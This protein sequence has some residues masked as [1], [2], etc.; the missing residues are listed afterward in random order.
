MKYALL[1]RGV[2]VG[3]RTKL[4]MTDLRAALEA[5]GFDDVSTYLQ[6]GNAVVSVP[7]RSTTTK[8]AERVRAAFDA[9]LPW[10]PGV[11][12]RSGTEMAAIRNGNPWPDAVS[13]P[14]FLNV[15]FLSV[16][17]DPQAKL[18]PDAWAPDEWAFGDHCVYLRYVAGSPGRSRLAEVVCR[19]ATRGNSAAIATVRNWNTVAAMA[20]RT[21]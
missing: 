7:G 19:E 17:P 8:V 4:A 10:S 18:D 6:S 1:L 11:V 13:E 3:A 15:A 2:N 12:V 20:D 5:A 14:K 9:G 16:Q 21:A